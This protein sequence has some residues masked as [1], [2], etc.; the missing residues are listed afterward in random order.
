MN[1]DS[2]HAWPATREAFRQAARWFVDT[3]SLVN[4]WERP[5]L[6]EW[7]VR[8]LV[9]HTSRALL[10]V[11][12]YLGQAPAASGAAVA[13]LSAVDYYP[14]ALASL[15]D[16]ATV[17][18]RGRDAGAALGPDPARQVSVIADRVLQLVAE[19]AGDAVVATPVGAM[20]LADYLPTR[21]FELTVHTCDLRASLGVQAQVPDAAA[22]V[23]LHL[24]GDLALRKGLAADLLLAA[25]GRGSLPAGFTVL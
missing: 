12:T 5:G 25:T 21:I 19:T 3:S 22:S 20:R 23:S 14:L 2:M 24:L 18:R 13:V 16:P 15:G 8:D 4:D 17:A 10:T 7:T 1:D 9:G 6:G 11:E